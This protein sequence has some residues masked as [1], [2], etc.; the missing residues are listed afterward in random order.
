MKV[1]SKVPGL[2]RFSYSEITVPKIN[3][4]SVVS[5]L[6]LTITFLGIV[7][8]FLGSS[9]LLGIDHFYVF[10]VT[11]HRMSFQSVLLRAYSVYANFVFN[12]L[13][14]LGFV[15][16]VILLLEILTAVMAGASENEKKVIWKRLLTLLAG[17]LFVYLLLFFFPLIYRWGE[18]SGREVAGREK[19]Q[20]DA[21][22]IQFTLSKEAYLVMPK[23]FKAANEAGELRFLSCVDNDYFVYSIKGRVNDWPPYPIFK[24]PGANV[25]LVRM[26]TLP[27]CKPK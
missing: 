18:A 26:V 23:D 15:L 12:N 10:A 22:E 1:A 25:V 6:T 9:F 19:P 7:F 24:V 20:C 14:V 11:D 27:S 3:W 21:Q 17:L 5:V 13:P 16:T 2:K 8:F 4:V